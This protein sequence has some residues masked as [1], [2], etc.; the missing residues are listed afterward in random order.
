MPHV[1]RRGARHIST[2]PAELDIDVVHGFLTSSYWATGI[3][4]ELVEQSIAGSIPF[5]VFEDGRQL[6]FARVISDRA[7]FAYIADVFVLPE[8]RGRGL[9][10]WLVETIVQHP[11]LQGLRRWTLFTADAHGLYAKVGFVPARRPERLMELSPGPGSR[12]V[13]PA[14]TRS[15]PEPAR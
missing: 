15:E 14:A 9:G 10:R 6:G 13:T 2:D 12:P 11:E 1:W 5:G 4:R 3:S 8:A 7:T